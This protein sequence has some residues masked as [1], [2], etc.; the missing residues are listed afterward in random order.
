MDKNSSLPGAA[1]SQSTSFQKGRPKFVSKSSAE[2]YVQTTVDRSKVFYVQVKG[3]DQ[4]N[5]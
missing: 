4:G 2:L 3:P 1:I 5:D